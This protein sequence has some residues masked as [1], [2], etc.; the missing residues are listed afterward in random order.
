MWQ[1][2]S[3]DFDKTNDLWFFSRKGKN[4]EKWAVGW[5]E[6]SVFLKGKIDQG[7]Y[8]VFF[9]L[10]KVIRV[11]EFFCDILLIFQLW[12]RSPGTIK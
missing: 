10:L 2:W 3:T 4:M 9:C 8:G 11:A 7:R 12:T 6:N 1:L 5:I